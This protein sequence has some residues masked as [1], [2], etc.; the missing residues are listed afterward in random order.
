MYIVTTSLTLL[1]LD[2][3]VPAPGRPYTRTPAANLLSKQAA[4]GSLSSGNSLSHCV[5]FKQARK[6]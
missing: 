3:H 4:N 2:M 5:S 1:P 6:A